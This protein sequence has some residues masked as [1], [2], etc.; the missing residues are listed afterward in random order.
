MD[1]RKMVKFKDW[2]AEKLKDDEFATLAREMEPGYQ[3]ARL[4][5]KEGLTQKELAEKAGTQ[6]SAI[7]RIENGMTM[8]TLTTLRKIGK[9]LNAKVHIELVTE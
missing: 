3:I 6:Q 8:P 5:I 2:E 1:S 7:A 9:A 4:R